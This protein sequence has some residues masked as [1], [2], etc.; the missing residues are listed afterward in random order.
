M[1]TWKKSF[2]ILSLSIIIIL[3]PQFTL[4]QDSEVNNETVINTFVEEFF[5]NHNLDVV[6][7]LLTPDFIAHDPV[8]G[9]MNRDEFVEFFENLFETQ[10][11]LSMSD[12]SLMSGQALVAQELPNEE[13]LMTPLGNLEYGVENEYSAYEAIYNFFSLTDGQVNEAWWIY[14]NLQLIRFTGVPAS[15]PD[16]DAPAGFM[17]N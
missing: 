5:N 1:D 8:H 4:A 10:P 11:N 12:Y 15:V 7:E 6:Y 13:S 16:F 14:N 9:D 17:G 2:I 3:F